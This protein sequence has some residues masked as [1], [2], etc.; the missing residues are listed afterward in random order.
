[1]ENSKKNDTPSEDI[2]NIYSLFEN[3]F[4]RAL[5]P[6]EIDTIRDWVESGYTLELIKSALGEAIRNKVPEITT[7]IQ[8]INLHKNIYVYY[9]NNNI[10]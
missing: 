8:N 7:I 1:M 6:F 4:G 2:D 9:I 10:F 3:E 5:T